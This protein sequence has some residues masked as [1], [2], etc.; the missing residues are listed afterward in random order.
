MNN[1]KATFRGVILLVLVSCV[2]LF[3]SQVQAADESDA[4]SATGF[5]V[6]AVIPDNQVDVM[7]TYF[8]LGIEPDTPQVIQVKVRSTQEAATT[9]HLTVHNAVSSS[10]GS[11]DYTRVNPKLDES[12]KNPVTDLVTINGGQ[13][14]VTVANYEEKTIEY[15]I[16]PPAENF[17][18]VKLGS[19]RFVDRDG[20]TQQAG[21]AALSSEYG[22][23]IALM[24]TEDRERFNL[25]ADLKLKNVNLKLSNGRKVIAANIQNDQPKVLQEMVIE[26]QVR[27]RG[28]S[29][30]I[31]SNRQTNFA[32][33]P[34]SNFDFQLPLDL[35]NFSAGTY[36]F[37]G[38]AEGA[39]RT[40]EWEEE[41]T[42]SGNR[43]AKINR[44]TVYKILIPGWV[45]WIAAGL[46]V[47]W[48]GL[49]FYLFRR[50]RRWQIKGE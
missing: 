47:I 25:G 4:Q 49:V 50:Q 1:Y 5:T 22:Y 9:V 16:Q 43:A 6:E 35:N 45:L 29:D 28:Q 46:F 32:V 40:W 42:V 34:N 21:Q 44:E 23:T 24:L 13:T 2:W 18:G 14:E 3:P 17:T 38:K 11:I 31:V 10:G 26:G 30:T 7:K 41:F 19:L 39:G 8:Y 27:R 33:A 12:L 48:L 15:T 20:G 36:V 37:T